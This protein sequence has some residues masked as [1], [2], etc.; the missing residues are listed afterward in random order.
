MKFRCLAFL[1][2]Q[3]EEYERVEHDRMEEQQMATKKIL[4]R[5]KQVH[6]LEQ[7]F[8][9]IPTKDNMICHQN[10]RILSNGKLKFFSYS[11]LIC[12]VP[13]H[14]RSIRMD[15]GQKEE[16]YFLLNFL[17]SKALLP[18]KYLTYGIHRRTTP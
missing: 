12:L 15:I 14:L 8:E 18:M 1:E 10:E 2:Q 6:P 7:Y 5:M 4:E 11:F 9:S 16:K 3:L 17:K 13:T